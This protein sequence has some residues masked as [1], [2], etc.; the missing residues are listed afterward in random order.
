MLFTKTNPDRPRPESV[1]SHMA[2]I[3]G[4]IMLAIWVIVARNFGAIA[5]LFGVDGLPERADG[6]YASL[7][8]VFLCAIPMVGWSLFVDKV[9]RRPSTGLDWSLKRPISETIDIS[10]VKLA[11]F[12]CTWVLLA[13]AYVTLRYYWQPPYTFAME[14][15]QFFVIPLVALSI[16]YVIWVDSHMVDPKNDAVYHFGAIIAGREDYDVGQIKHHLRN[17]LVKGFFCAFMVSI[18]P[19]GWYEIVN[20]DFGAIIGDPRVFAGLMIA[21]LFLVD[22]QIATVGYLLTMK[23]LDSHIRSANPFMQGWIAALICYPPLV[24]MSQN[25]TIDYHQ[26]TAD[27]AYWFADHPVLLML[28]AALLIWLTG[29]YAWATVAFGL[30]FSNLTYRGVITHG[31]YAWTKHPA[32]LCKNTFWWCVTLPFLVTSGDPLEAMRN[33]VMIIIVSLIYYWR[34]RTEEAHLRLE[35]PAYV[36][37]EQWMREFGPVPRFVNGIKARLAAVR[38]GQV[39]ADTRE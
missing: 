26:D 18:L 13:F 6:P 15:F 27:W 23:P 38:R 28:W 9:H 33:T 1:S 7:L 8:S 11:G 5:A 34:A 10:V 24:L 36:E 31:P 2:G 20:A 22:V 17:W 32:Y 14:T 3:S 16:P 25:A 30:R 39:V 12:W 37:Y 21:V 29:I 35:D 4:V 19:G